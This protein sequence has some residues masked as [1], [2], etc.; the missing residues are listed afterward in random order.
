MAKQIGLCTQMRFS[1]AE[2]ELSFH[3]VFSKTPGALGKAGETN[4]R[5]YLSLLGIFISLH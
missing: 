5:F 4:L 1:K 3:F 2:I